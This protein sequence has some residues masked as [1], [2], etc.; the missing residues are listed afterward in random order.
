MRRAEARGR[1]RQVQSAADDSL[2]L[3]QRCAHVYDLPLYRLRRK[4]QQFQDD[5]RLRGSLSTRF[6]IRDIFLKFS[7]CPGRESDRM[8]ATGC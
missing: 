4:R 5:Q 7:M 6:V 1:M 8:T 3:E 2:L